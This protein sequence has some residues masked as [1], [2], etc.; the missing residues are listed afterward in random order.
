VL[1]HPS[2]DNELN[3][4]SEAS[5]IKQTIRECR[6]DGADCGRPDRGQVQFQ[7]FSYHQPKDAHHIFVLYVERYTGM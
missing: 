5:V 1:I 7:P 6:S 3:K 2:E 4:L